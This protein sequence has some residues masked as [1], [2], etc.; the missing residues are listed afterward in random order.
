MPSHFIPLKKRSEPFSLK[1]LFKPVCNALPLVQI[2]KSRSNRPMTFSFEYH[3][4]ALIYLH[5]QEYESGRELLQVLEE[6]EFAKEYI[7]PPDGVARST[8]FEAMNTRALPQLIKMYELLQQQ[9]KDILPV[10]SL[11]LGKLVAVDGSL[12]DA[13]PTMEF[14]DYR[15]G[16]KKAKVHLG[17]N[18]N[19]GIPERIVLSAGKADERPF[20]K[21]LVEPGQTMIADRYYQCHK[22]FD[23][24][25]TEERH[26]V[27][28]I[29]KSTRKTI[30]TEHKTPEDSHIFLDVTTLLGTKGQ[31]QTEKPVRVVGY[32]IDQV[33]YFV[34]TD[35]FDLT[36][37][38]VALAYKL[39]WDIEKFFSWW[40]QHLNV[41]HVI[42]RSAHG[43]MA[44]MLGGLITYLLLAI[45]CHD[46]HK[47][48][49][50]ISR[51]RE[52]RI[53]IRNELSEI[54]TDVKEQQ[55][56]LNSS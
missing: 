4:K 47:E 8:F 56:H 50:S 5:L 35:R 46:E 9:A 13:V 3:L 7:A 25:Q 10:S 48:R 51:V 33:D 27:I 40:K 17:F 16:V 18:I 1:R 44:Q 43:L 38:Q 45:Y 54:L 23:E 36:A 24:Y 41:Y 15:S 22:N 12:I 19:H 52:L 28:R 39:R 11:E 6:D 20:V 29:K 14:A 53:K 42:A 26:F 30:I 34:A 32:R 21:K 2:P 49:V 31:N 55:E 37:E